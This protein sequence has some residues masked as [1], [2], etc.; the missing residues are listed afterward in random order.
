MRL[1]ILLSLLAFVVRAVA[2]GFDSLPPPNDKAKA[3]KGIFNQFGIPLCGQPCYIKAVAATPCDV[4]DLSCV[5]SP[6]NSDTVKAAGLPCVIDKCPMTE[7]QK[8]L[9]G[10][11]A[12][13]R[14]VGIE[15]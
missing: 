8:A 4:A 5:C 14:S 1:T 11:R 13:C 12:A 10:V 15:V 3:V 2:A 6:A 7:W 9:V